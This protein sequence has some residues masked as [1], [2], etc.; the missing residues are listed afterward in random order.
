ME[1]TVQGALLGGSMLAIAQDLDRE[2]LKR[3]D[4][5]ANSMSGVL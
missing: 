5:K 4:W 3:T 1:T 2:A